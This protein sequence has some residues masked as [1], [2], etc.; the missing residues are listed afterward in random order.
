MQHKFDF[1]LFF[2]GIP[3]AVLS[4]AANVFP[5]ASLCNLWRRHPL[6]RNLQCML[7]AVGL[8][9]AVAY[10]L[11]VNLPRADSP[12]P[13][14]PRTG[15]P[16]IE[17]ATLLIVVI[18]TLGLGSATGASGA[19]EGRGRGCQRMSGAA[20]PTAFAPAS[21]PPRCCTPEEAPPRLPCNPTPGLYTHTRT[22]PLLSAAPL[23]RHFDLEGKDD[24]A[25]LGLGWSEALA[26]GLSDGVPNPIEVE[27]GSSLHDRF[28]VRV[29]GW[30]WL[31]VVVVGGG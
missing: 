14:A 9:G 18:S 8:R 27:E 10:G 25:L 17:T 11:V 26:E 5:C 22:P 1:G 12:D 19:V 13:A 29:G 31:K 30:L 20:A 21:S 15:I 6:P 16:A 3:L 4:R 24:A 23:L 28:K 7:W 2:S